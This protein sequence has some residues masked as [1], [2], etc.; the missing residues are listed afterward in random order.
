MLQAIRDRATGIFAWA[1][2]LF[3]IASFALWGIHSYFEAPSNPVVA[4]VGSTEITKLELQRAYDQRYQR[5]QN[6]MGDNFRHDLIDPKQFRQNVL[7]EL[8]QSALMEQ[9]VD[10][11]DY[12]VG[13]TD[14]AGYL[15]ATPAFQVNGQFSPETYKELLAR[16][17]MKATAFEAQL[18]QSMEMEQ[19]R[20]GLLQ[21]G[22]VTQKDID[23]AWRIQ[24]ER[25]NLAYV[26]FDTARYEAQI[27]P[28]DA[29]IAARYEADKKRYFTPER[30]RV[31]YI[32]LDKNTLPPASAP[33]DEMLRALYEAE[34]QTRFARPEQRQ[35]RHILIRVVGNSGEAQALQKARE[36]RSQIEK[37][38]DFTALA[39]QY[40]DDPGSKDKGGLLDLSPK[41]TL[42]PAFDD[43][44][45]KLKQGELSQ[46]VRTSFGWH[47]IQLE[48]LVPQQV[49]QF[50]DPAVREELLTM[51]RGREI[52][53]RY[54]QLAD[55]LDELSFEHPDS[56][57]P[58]A[59]AVGLKVEQSDWMTRGGGAGIGAI[60]D[61]VEAAFSDTVIVDHVNS[62][63]VKAGANRLIV[64]RVRDHE[65]PRQR[66]L[67]E[68]R[69]VLVKDL[70][71]QRARERAI[72]QGGKALTALKQGRNLDDV[73]TSAGLSVS[74]PGLIE[75]SA[76]QVPAPVV[77]EAFRMPRPAAG[78][79]SYSGLPLA[80][81]GY[82]VLALQSVEDA[83]PA[84]ATEA[85][86][87]ALSQALTGRVAGAEFS[88]LKDA[89][90]KDIKV[91]INEDQ[92]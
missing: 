7:D 12:R 92:L 21:T 57:Q 85:D 48:K 75:R 33:E 87:Q 71:N 78:Q 14:V 36:V 60:K 23:N 64:L 50:N 62:A 79:S 72:E 66:A 90:R 18:R 35:A 47:I 59:Q 9:Y 4:K 25:R 30:V 70:K 17:G 11:A 45:F 77:T 29:E 42:D 37:G 91:K 32:E 88:A 69:D 6:L 58:I 67:A 44:L 39:K 53:E 68:V 61:I 13:N 73:A 80:D 8:I 86:R 28:S 52:D 83:D 65:A 76:T 3:L 22:F 38:G 84:K 51:Y 55:K 63:P 89:L 24:H 10:Q 46:P 5:L 1:I 19:M 82:A 49:K 40:S 31:D 43:A 27:S 41:G 15:R 20:T 54:K 34:K 56:L 26:L 81:G 2:L 74:R 16:E